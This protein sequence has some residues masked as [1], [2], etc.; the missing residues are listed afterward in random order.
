MDDIDHAF[1][2]LDLNHDGSI[3]EEEF[4]VWY[5]S[6]F[7]FQERVRE[8]TENLS[9]DSKEGEGIYPP[10]PKGE[11]TSA[12]VLY[13]ITCPL[14]FTLYSTVPN[15]TRPEYKSMYLITF[16]VSILWIGIFSCTYIYP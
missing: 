13:I 12:K 11:S 5:D 4:G 10:F 7:F 15:V 8:I 16:I 14:I 6:S 2:Q 3:S 9:K 1:Q